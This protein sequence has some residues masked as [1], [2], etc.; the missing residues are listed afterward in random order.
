VSIKRVFVDTEFTSFERPRLLSIGMCSGD[1]DYFYAEISVP[2]DEC[3]EFVREKIVPQLGKEPYKICI[4]G[5]ELAERISVWLALQRVDGGRLEVCVDYSTDW[6]LLKDALGGNVPDW[7]Y[8]RMIADH[9]DERMRL[10]YY[11]L[12]NVAEHHA[13]HD[14]LANQYAYQDNLPLT[15]ALDFLCP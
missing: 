14:A 6:D 10:E 7:C 4:N 2:T 12:H 9:L 3:S 5:G 8:Q 1:G 11:R 15:S 13:L